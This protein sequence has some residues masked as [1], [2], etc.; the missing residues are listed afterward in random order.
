MSCKTLLFSILTLVSTSTIL[1]Q[2]PIVKIDFDQSGRSTTE[3]GEP[4]YTP[5]VIA[6]GTTASKTENGV[7]F[8]ITKGT[9]GTQLATNWLQIGTKLDY[10]LPITQ[11][12]SVMELP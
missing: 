7:T 4:G 12:W 10:W 2:N 1:A 8:K 9:N 11:D 3:V 5:W 6:S